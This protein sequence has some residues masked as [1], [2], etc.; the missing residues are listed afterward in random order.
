MAHSSNTQH[1][2][3]QL[4]DW[5]IFDSLK[6]GL[7]SFQAWVSGNIGTQIEIGF[8]KENEEEASCWNS[9][10]GTVLFCREWDI[11]SLYLGAPVLAMGSVEGK[12]FVKGEDK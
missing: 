6:G 11:S 12:V 5:N 2:G 10:E 8:Q 3:K 1:S 9:A 4:M 7:W